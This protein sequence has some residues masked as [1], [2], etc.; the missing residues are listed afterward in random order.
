[1]SSHKNS[2]LQN[3]RH[4][5]K[6][7]ANNDVRSSDD[8]N[9]SFEF[10]PPKNEKMNDTLWQ[11]IKKLEPLNPKFVSV[12][13]G[14]GGSTRERTHNT[15]S[16]IAEETD[17]Q[18]AA[19]LT[20]VGS[21][22]EEIDEIAQAY[23]DAGIRHVVALRGDPEAG[24]GEAYQPVAG[25][26]N[27]GSD[28]V[29]GLKKTAP[30]EVSVGAYP[31]LHPESGS[32]DTELDNLKRKIDAGA[33]RAITQFF[34]E[35]DT[36]LRFQD[37]A[38]DAGINIPIV[39]GLML[40]PN[41]KGLKRMSEMCAISVPNWLETLY[42]DLDD[43]PQARLLVTATTIADLAANLREQGVRDLHFYT[44]NK[45]ELAFSVCK[46]LG[47]RTQKKAVA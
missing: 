2:K 29:A 36:F 42:A 30:F 9:I 46:I 7:I 1:M 45:A 34:F 37:K 20:C 27:Y 12:T 33:D 40:Q 23:W 18:A 35:A 21:R 8:L 26:Y 32:W 11:T 4:K 24:I 43:D 6:S 13:Y 25:G 5:M 3:S 38:A 15:V 19:H 17:L 31:E 44:L 14:A 47:F 16:R 22:R 10:F 28:L 41:F 39:P